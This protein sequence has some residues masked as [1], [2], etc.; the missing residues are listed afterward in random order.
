MSLGRP[1]V[2]KDGKTTLAIEPATSDGALFVYGGELLQYQVVNELERIQR[3]GWSVQQTGGG[4]TSAAIRI[5]AKVSRVSDILGPEILQLLKNNRFAQ[6]DMQSFRW[7]QAGRIPLP[8][9][10]RLRLIH[11]ASGPE[12]GPDKH[13]VRLEKPWFFRIDFVIEPIAGSAPGVVPSGLTVPADQLKE[14]R[15]FHFSVVMRARFELL[16][17]GNWQTEEHKKWAEWLFAKLQ[18]AMSD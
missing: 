1:A 6:G 15:T 14:L 16:T 7:E 8:E 18:D 2:T 12:T 9:G 13:M 17:S 11:E 10:T 4:S 3:A 5:P